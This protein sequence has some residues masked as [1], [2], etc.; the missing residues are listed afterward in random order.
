MLAPGQVS[1]LTEMGI[2][3][4]EFR[5]QEILKPSEVFNSEIS[6]VEDF[7]SLPNVDCLVV[8]VEQD[9]SAET[10]RL[11]DAMLFSIG[12]ASNNSAI[13]S[14]NQLSQ[15]HA[16]ISQHKVIVAFGE[17]LIPE[18]LSTQAIDRGQIYSSANSAVKIII[19]LSLNSLLESPANKA[20]AWQDL[21]LVKTAYSPEYSE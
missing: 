1:S 2:P 4:W 5:S 13:V 6:E 17:Q 19:S 12:L 18:V 8:V 11:L 9:I 15:L 16:E 14:P 21:Q 7:Q 3:V 10:Q 20:L